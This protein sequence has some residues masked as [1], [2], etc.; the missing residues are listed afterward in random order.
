M[1]IR[2]RNNVFIIH[3]SGVDLGHYLLLYT[4]LVLTWGPL[5]T[6][7]HPSTAVEGCKVVCKGLDKIIINNVPGQHQSGVDL[8]HQLVERCKNHLKIG[9]FFIH[10]SG[11]DLGHYLLLYTSLV[12]TWGSLHTTLHTSTRAG[13]GM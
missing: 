13:G 1:C 10:Q 7:L 5:H 6:T 8:S 11:V 12:L 4:S 9:I 2:D 3:Q